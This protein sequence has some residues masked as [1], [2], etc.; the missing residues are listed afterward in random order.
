[1]QRKGKTDRYIECE[2]A[3]L[4]LELLFGLLFRFELLF[5]ARRE[6]NRLDSHITFFVF[7]FRRIFEI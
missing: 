5:I 4:L 6:H 7:L 1:M 2:Q 3:L